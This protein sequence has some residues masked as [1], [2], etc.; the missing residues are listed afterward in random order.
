MDLRRVR[1]YRRGECRLPIRS[2]QRR[3]GRERSE[4]ACDRTISTVVNNANGA[5][6]ATSTV[7][8]NNG[9][10]TNCY[11]PTG[12]PGN[13]TWGSAVACGSACA[14]G[15]VAGQ[16]VTI[17]ASP[18]SAVSALFPTYNLTYSGT[19]SRSAIVETQ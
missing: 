2:K 16:F 13:W 19:I 15:G 14:G 11:C 17:T 4:R 5:G 8:V 7:N 12:T 3:H 10:S 1:T 6:W 18:S 9:S